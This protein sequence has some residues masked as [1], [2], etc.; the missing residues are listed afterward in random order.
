M[1]IDPVSWSLLFDNSHYTTSTPV[2][3]SPLLGGGDRAP[4]RALRAGAPLV[5]AAASTGST[6]GALFRT[7]QNSFA[8]AYSAR[9]R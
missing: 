8:S 9:R 4:R 5:A 7:P 2:R 6:E 3:D 1:R